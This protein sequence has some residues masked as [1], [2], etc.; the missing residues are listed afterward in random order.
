MT[1]YPYSCLEQRF[2]KLVALNDRAGWG[3]SR[4][5][6]AHQ[7]RAAPQVLRIDWLEGDDALT[8]YVLARRR[9]AAG[10]CRPPCRAGR[11]TV[12]R[13]S[14]RASCRGVPGLRRRPGGPKAGRHRGAV[15]LRRATPQ[16]LE[17]LTIDPANWPSSALLDWIGILQRVEAVP[18]R[19]G[20][21]GEARRLLR[22]RLDL[23]GTALRFRNEPADRLW[24]LMVS[25][26]SNA[27][28]LLLAAVDDPGWREEIRARL[29]LLGRLQRGHW[30]TTRCER[31]GDPGDARF[32]GRFEPAPVTGPRR[33][34]SAPA[35]RPWIGRRT[36]ARRPS[37]SPGRVT[38]GRHWASTTRGRAG[39]GPSCRAGRPSPWRH[40]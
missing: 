38:R 15:A 26:D 13:P 22:G 16:Q 20:R 5:S 6:C 9:K 23:Q 1:A 2:S 4:S 40:P 35:A 34:S 33:R 7:D 8:A 31:L 27:A 24:W 32:S 14:S 36:S 18:D 30:D 39:P 19:E 28:R 10:S 25:G 17:S 11:W 3:L 21:L 37:T 12:S 29:G